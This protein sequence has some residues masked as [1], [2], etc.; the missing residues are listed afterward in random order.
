[1]G[2]KLVT[3]TAKV[4]SETKKSKDK[5]AVAIAYEHIPRNPAEQNHGSLYGIIEL[6]DSSGKAEEI[7]E[8][9]I[10]ALHQEFYEDTSREPL[11]SFEAALAKINEDLAD[12]SG[13]G[14]IN[15]LGKLNAVLAVLS[16][17]T[18]HLTQAGKAEAYLYRGEHSMHI[19]EDLSGD[20]VNPLRTFINVA[21]GD[22]AENDKLIFVTPGVFYKLSKSE[23]KN[24]IQS[25]TP[26]IAVENISKL[27]SGESGTVLPNAVLV[28]EMISP[29][30]YAL[31]PEPQIPTETWVK[32]EGK[33]IEVV[34]QKS[35]KGATKVFDI[36]GKAARGTSTFI[37]A[38]AFPMVKTGAVKISG[39]IKDFRK[40]SRAESVIL[41]SEEK[42]ESTDKPELDDIYDL[43]DNHVLEPDYDTQKFE[44]EIRIKEEAKPKMISLERFNF[45]AF[46]GGGR[47][48]KNITQKIRIPRGRN[49]II[50][51]I[52]GI[53]LILG[54]FGF[55]TVRSMERKSQTEAQNIYNQAKEKFDAAVEEINSG[56]RVLAIED[57]ETA[58]K[59]ANDAKN[60]K[61][62]KADAEKLLAQIAATKDKAVGL[63]KNTARL[64]LDPEKGTLDGFF[65]DGTL[66]Y[67]VSYKSGSVYSIDPKAKTIAT[68][69]ENPNIS[70]SIK[71]GTLVSTRDT[72]VL[73]TQDKNVYEVDLVSKK[74]TKQ[75]IS[76]TWEDAADMAS[77][78]T[79]I[80]L[81]SPKNNQIYKHLKFAGGYTQKTDY[82]QNPSAGELTSA[83][84]IGI[85]SDV[86]VTDASGQVT[87]YT[88]G[89]KVPYSISGLPEEPTGIRK[90]YADSAVRGLY[91]LSI[92]K[93]YRIDG[94]ARY[95]GQYQSDNVKDI[96][97][98]Y[99]SDDSR[100]IFILS[101]GKIYALGF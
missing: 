82:V 30:T 26:K 15:W 28:I 65:S 29:E 33:P 41:A 44:K 100:M 47:G 55:L 57:L 35:I 76:G 74:V 46:K 24:Y 75:F 62:K 95:T 12:R 14:Q 81:L 83:V 53:V 72:L 51:L 17:N 56:N 60:T 52:A 85:D 27:L 42:L 21:S 8:G 11:A 84:G 89:K 68:I 97:N 73:Y 66:L 48:F 49:S 25:N 18:I 7:A 90:V 78:F 91:L 92:D 101:E 19:T 45:S 40:E 31:E 50:Y 94:N 58:E 37:S 86:Y 9:I 88:V 61:Y 63:V 64:F 10:A 98:I 4:L 67:A 5:E 34:S 16:G 77:Y 36:L 54:L 43:D 20:N 99:V 87:K 69:V 6:E 79:N 96:K 38:K 71:F 22:L 80:Y 3:K 93:I 2:N 13:E 70:A 1:M 32:E 59:L 39:K 23:L